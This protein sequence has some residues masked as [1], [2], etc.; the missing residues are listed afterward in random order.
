[1]TFLTLKRTVSL[2]TKSSSPHFL[3]LFTHQL[4]NAC[5]NTLNSMISYLF[6][7]R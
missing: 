7:R 2:T 3:T 5:V 6:A 1:M 4:A